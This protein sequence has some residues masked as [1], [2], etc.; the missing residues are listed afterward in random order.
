MFQKRLSVLVLPLLL[1]HLLLPAQVTKVRGQVLDAETGAPVPFAGVFFTGTTVGIS[2]DLDGRYYLETTDSEAKELQA[3]LIGYATVRKT[4]QTGAFNEVDFLLQPV[5]DELSA[6]RVKPDNRRIRRFLRELDR[7]RERHN[8]D[9]YPRWGVRLYSRIEL[10]ATNADVFIRNPLLERTLAP[11][12]ACRDT[13]TVSGV[14][15]YPILLSET[16]SRHY[17]SLEPPVD[18]EIVDANR[19]TGIEPDNLL[20]QFSGRYLLRANL[21]ENNISLFNLQIPS[22]VSAYGHPFYNYYLVDSLEVDGRKTYCLRFHP[23]A[24]VTSPTL[25]GQVNVDAEDYSIRSARVRLADKSNVNWIRHI[26]YSMDYR[27]LPTGEWFPGEE[28]MYIDF[29]IAVSDSSKVVSFLGKRQQVYEVPS[30]EE[31]LPEAYGHSDDPVIVESVGKE[32]DWENTRL[33]PL[34]PREERIVEAVDAVQHAP[35]YNAL[36]GL[37]R[38]LVVGYVEWGHTPVAV[39]PWAKTVTYNP[40]E[41][42]HLGT[43]FRTTRFFHP[44]LRLAGSIGYGFRDKEI[45]GGM[46]VEYMFRRDRTRKLTGAFS[47]DYVQLG[48]GFGALSDNTVFNSLMKHRNDR[49]SLL[50]VLRLEYEHELTRWASFTVEATGSRVFGNGMVP[51]QFRSGE[52]PGRMDVGQVRLNGRFAWEERINRGFFDKAHIF[53]KYP[54]LSFN[55]TGGAYSFDRDHSHAGP[56]FRGEVSLDWNTPGTPVGFSSLHVNSGKVWGQVPYL[57]LKLHEGNQGW[58]L[59]RT[60]FSCMDYFEFASDAWVDVFIEHNFNGLLLGKIPLVNRL[61]WREIVSFKAAFGSIRDENLGNSP[62]VPIAHMGDLRGQPYYEMGVGLSNIFRL[63]RID[64]AWRLSRRDGS[65]RNACVMVGMDL[66][67]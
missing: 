31:T 38:S 54:V 56:Y 52:G 2:A 11:I 22:P 33:I 30:F 61:D 42:L 46:S 26:D 63:F 53:T 57:L 34:T 28:S 14:P 64:Y 67:F 18:R 66:K 6:A 44:K 12:A 17:H 58:F 49:Q 47:R 41:G 59:D 3:S 15:Y 19:I 39:G 9:R 37:A 40:T 60:A 5:P 10:D 36:Y 13:S 62:L 21:Y 65:G 43:G 45:K 29:S 20:T 27:R 32:T 24:A 50:S 23:K 35:A 16:F 1:V 4:V 51:L 48:Q 55:L 8:P 25:D 7:N